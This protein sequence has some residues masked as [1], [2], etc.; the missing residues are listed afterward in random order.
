MDDWMDGQM[1]DGMDE[2]D[3]FRGSFISSQR[4]LIYVMDGQMDDGMDDEPI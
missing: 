2:T 4:L 1:D 3:G